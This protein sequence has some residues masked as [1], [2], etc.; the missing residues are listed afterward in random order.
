M[1]ELRADRLVHGR[2]SQFDG[3]D[4]GGR[5]NVTGREKNKQKKMSEWRVAS[6]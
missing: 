5:K 4:G 3:G 6:N 2:N 1:N